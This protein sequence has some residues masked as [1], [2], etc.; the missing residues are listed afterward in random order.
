M[1]GNGLKFLKTEFPGKWKCLTKKVA[2][3]YEY[4][5]SIEDCQKPVDKLKK[6]DFFSQLKNG[7]PDDEEI[8]RT[9]DNIK[10]FNI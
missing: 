1:V 2:Y 4:F 10:E 9:M 7:Y 8:E 3:P 6:E 5:D